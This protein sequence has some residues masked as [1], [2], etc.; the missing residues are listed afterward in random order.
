ME[1]VRDMIITDLGQEFRLYNEY[2]R[3]IAGYIFVEAKEKLECGQLLTWK[4]NRFRAKPAGRHDTPI[5]ATFRDMK[6]GERD[7]VKFYGP[8]NIKVKK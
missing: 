1:E 7:L 8:I 5:G 3:L 4:K 2:S 6:K